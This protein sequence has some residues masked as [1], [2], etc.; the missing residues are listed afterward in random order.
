MTRPLQ[1]AVA[2]DELDMRDFF[3]RSLR[4]LGHLVVGVAENGRELVALVR[5]TRPDLVIT[6]IKMP[7]LDGINAAIQIHRECPV[8]VILVSAYSDAA[9]L[10]RAESAHI[11]GYLVKPIKHADL[12][13]VITLA[14]RRFEQFED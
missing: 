14:M 8:P 11:L 7:E 2:D 4:R 3:E 10:K 1:I 9:L 6:D 12:E 5:S 13:P